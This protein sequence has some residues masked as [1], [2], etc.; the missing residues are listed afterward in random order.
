[1]FKDYDMSVLYHPDKAKVVTHTLTC[2][3]MG[4]ISHIHEAIK[5]LVRDVHRLTAFWVRLEDSSN[6]RVIFHHNSDSSL[7]IE[8]MSKQHHDE[9]LMELK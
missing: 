9:Q 3:T 6:G 1:M 7:V 8:V 2:M 4:S 5:F